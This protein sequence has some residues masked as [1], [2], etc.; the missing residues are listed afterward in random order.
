MMQKLSSEKLV[1]TLL[2]SID[3]GLIA[4]VGV[5]Q[6][7]ELLLNLVEQLNSKV[8]QLEEENQQLRDENNLL[9]GELGKP[10]IK[11]SKKKG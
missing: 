1:A 9:K 5:R 3:P 8:T 4:D 7:V 2:R 6:T 11:A 10:D